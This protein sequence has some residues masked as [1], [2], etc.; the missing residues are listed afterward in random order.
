MIRPVLIVIS[1][2]S[3]WFVPHKVG[4]SHTT[5]LPIRAAASQ[6]QFGPDRDNRRY[7][8]RNTDAFNS[9]LSTRAL[10]FLIASRS[11]SYC[12]R[13]SNFS[14]ANTSISSSSTCSSNVFY[15]STPTWQCSSAS[16]KV[17]RPLI[18]K[19]K[20]I[21]NHMAPESSDHW[22]SSE[23]ILSSGPRNLASSSRR[24]RL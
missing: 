11:A 7:Q 12:F 5:H 3:R 4:G 22:T 6:R 16:G 24:T 1:T 21:W 13:S 18:P 17:S 9:P 23:K 8:S 19:V 2:L 10:S 20:S 15:S 14:S